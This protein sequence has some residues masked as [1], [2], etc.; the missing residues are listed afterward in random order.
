MMRPL[1]R[2]WAGLRQR[3][4]RA[5]PSGSTRRLG[6]LAEDA[7]ARWLRRRGYRILERN[8]RL[9]GGEIDFLAFRAGWLVVIEVRSR[10]QGSAVSPRETLTAKKKR[11]LRRL[12]EQVHKRPRWRRLSL[13]IDLVEV[14]TD[15]R[16]RVVS[17]QAIEGFC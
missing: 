16:D 1:H 17:I 4:F 6:R 5:R 7:A 14:E 9:P 15:A 8:L 10:K 12:A 13:R 11:R 3:W 2:I